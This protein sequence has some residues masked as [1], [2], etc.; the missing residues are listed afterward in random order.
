MLSVSLLTE[1]SQARDPTGATPPFYL[2]T[3]RGPSSASMHLGH[4][5]PFM[6]TQWLQRA[7]DVPLVI[8]VGSGLFW[9]DSVW[10][11]LVRCVMMWFGLVWFGLV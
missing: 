5:V 10:F 4:L 2:Y 3:G 11:G 9:F 6:M 1:H 8:Q 7:F